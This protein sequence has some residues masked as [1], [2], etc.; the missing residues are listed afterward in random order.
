MAVTAADVIRLAPEF[1]DVF[2][3][4]VEAFIVQAQGHLNV[5]V[6][7][8]KYDRG[9]ALYAAHLLAVTYPAKLVQTPTSE[10]IQGVSR[11]FSGVAYEGG[12]GNRFYAEFQRMMAGLGA[13]MVAT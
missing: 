2:V 9:V 12:A 10:S 11:G 13:T 6:W 8:T 7:G 3:E 1:R 5:T 4:D